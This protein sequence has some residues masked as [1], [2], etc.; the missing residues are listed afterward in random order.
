VLLKRPENLTDHQVDR[1]QDLHS[2]NLKT[3]RAYLLKENFQRIWEYHSPVWAG[4]FLDDWCT[5]TMRSR[6][7]PMKKVVKMLRTHWEL[8]LKRFLP[9]GRLSQ[10]C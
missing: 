7:P 8:L 9:K 6:L 3:I 4:R 2:C 1:L 10:P 5:R